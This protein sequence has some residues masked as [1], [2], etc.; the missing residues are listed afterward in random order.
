MTFLSP[1]NK[2]RLMWIRTSTQLIRMQTLCQQGKNSDLMARPFRGKSPM[3]S[4]FH[5]SPI[6]SLGMD[7]TVLVSLLD[8]GIHFMLRVDGGTR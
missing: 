6:P 7:D 2:R 5:P 8:H 4:P 3:G 1:T